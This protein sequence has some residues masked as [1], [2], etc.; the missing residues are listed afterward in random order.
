[1]FLTSGIHMVRGRC[2]QM[3][4]TSGVHI[5]RG[6][7]KQM[8]LTSGV[9]I[10]RGRCKQMFLTSGVNMA[11]GRCEQ[12]FLSPGVH[13]ARGRSKEMFLTSGVHI[14][15]DLFAPE[16]RLKTFRIGQQL[17]K[18]TILECQI[19]AYPMAVN[20]WQKDGSR[21]MSSTKYR[22]D[23]YDEEYHTITLSLHI[24]NIA[25]IDYGEYTCMANNRLGSDSKTMKLSKI[26][27]KPRMPTPPPSGSKSPFPVAPVTLLPGNGAAPVVGISGQYMRVDNKQPRNAN[28]ITIEKKEPKS[29]QI[30]NKGCGSFG[31]TL[32]LPLLWLPLVAMLSMTS[33]GRQL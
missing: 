23:A 2:K 22:L 11:R 7:C 8:F 24:M 15:R 3:F 20:Y 16:I 25:E 10:S 9:H 6:R 30:T 12:M 32:W 4:L 31:S 19:T 18:D 5:A 33:D 13:I 26:H 21:I 29:Q 27:N 28:G 1:M 14:V 17:E